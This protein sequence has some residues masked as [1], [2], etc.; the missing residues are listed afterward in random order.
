MKLYRNITKLDHGRCKRMISKIKKISSLSLLLLMTSC[1]TFIAR[2]SM[3]P[4]IYPGPKYD[5]ALYEPLVK[6][7]D[8]PIIAPISYASVYIYIGVAWL[9]DGVFDTLALPYDLHK[10]DEGKAVRQAALK[11]ARRVEGG[12]PR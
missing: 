11:A 2:D 10:V 12:K 8:S 3:P 1:N 6:K 4:Q 9:V 7:I 5:L